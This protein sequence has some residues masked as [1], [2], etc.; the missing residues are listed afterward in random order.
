VCV[1][2]LMDQELTSRM[3]TF[4]TSWRSFVFEKFTL[5]PMGQEIV[6]TL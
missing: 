5:A 3:L 1:C 2:V 6:L 4:L